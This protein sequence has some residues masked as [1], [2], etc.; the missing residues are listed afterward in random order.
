MHAVLGAAPLASATAGGA[1]GTV[2]RS[3][4][5]AVRLSKKDLTSFAYKVLYAVVG[6]VLGFV[7]NLVQAEYSKCDVSQY[8][9]RSSNQFCPMP[10][11]SI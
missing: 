8:L 10:H 6:L 11:F 3:V 4:D 9:I 7:V 2:C 5:R 1:R